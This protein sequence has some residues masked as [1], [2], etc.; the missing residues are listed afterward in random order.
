VRRRDADGARQGTFI[1]GSP[2]GAGATPAPDA[3]LDVIDPF[4]IVRISGRFTRSRTT[5]T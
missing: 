2:A 1:S 3:S 5:L 4:P